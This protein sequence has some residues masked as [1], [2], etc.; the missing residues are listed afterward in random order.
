MHVLIS[1]LTKLGARVTDLSLRVQLCLSK[2]MNHRSSLHD[3]IRSRA[4]ECLNL[5]R[6]SSVAYALFERPCS[7]FTHHS[8]EFFFFF[9]FFSFFFFRQEKNNS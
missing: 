3:S 8:G 5:L 2:I 7:T 1:A 4:V 6:V 9:L